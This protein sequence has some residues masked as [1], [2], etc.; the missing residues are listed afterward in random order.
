L[1]NIKKWEML[2][3]EAEEAQNDG[4]PSRDDLPTGDPHGDV[5]EIRPT[6]ICVKMVKKDNGDIFPIKDGVY[7]PYVEGYKQWKK[8]QKEYEENM[9]PNLVEPE[10]KVFTEEPS[11]N[12][13]TEAV[14]GKVPLKAHANYC[15]LVKNSK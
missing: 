15:D 7:D 12:C 4:W 14:Y 8:S 9:K 5:D 1:S 11:C 6:N 13:G 2:E 3:K 10:G